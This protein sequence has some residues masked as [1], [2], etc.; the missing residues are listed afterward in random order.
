MFYNIV[1][2][3]FNEAWVMSVMKW[4]QSKNT[5]ILNNFPYIRVLTSYPTKFSYFV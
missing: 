1:R 5:D 2:L 4:K 3:K